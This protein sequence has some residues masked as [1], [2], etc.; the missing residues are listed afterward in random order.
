M[1]TETQW[2]CQC[3]QCHGVHTGSDAVQYVWEFVFGDCGVPVVVGVNAGPDGHVGCAFP[4]WHGEPDEPYRIGDRGEF[5]VSCR[6]GIGTVPTEG[7]IA[8]WIQWEGSALPPRDW[9]IADGAQFRSVRATADALRRRAPMPEEQNIAGDWDGPPTDLA[10]RDRIR[11]EW[12]ETVRRNRA[13][14]RR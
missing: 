13:T 5:V 1:A 4:Y 11:M 10:H 7:D 6:P 8:R 3:R 14:S 12:P 2:I 9:L